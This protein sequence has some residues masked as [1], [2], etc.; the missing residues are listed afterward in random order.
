M[1]EGLFIGLMEEKNDTE[2]N[3]VG[4]GKTPSLIGI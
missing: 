3:V 1:K 4:K 2:D